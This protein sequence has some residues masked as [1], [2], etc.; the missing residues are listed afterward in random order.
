MSHLYH[1]FFSQDGKA[2]RFACGMGQ[3]FDP[4]MGL[5]YYGTSTRCTEPPSAAVKAVE[6]LNHAVSSFLYPE[7]IISEDNNNVGFSRYSV[8]LNNKQF[9]PGKHTLGFSKCQT[10]LSKVL[11]GVRL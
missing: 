1:L 4:A 10:V 9:L 11:I 3:F 2:Y 7:T 5:C 6:D 8:K